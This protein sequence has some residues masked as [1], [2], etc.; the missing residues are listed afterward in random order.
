MVN[1]IYTAVVKIPLTVI[2]KIQNGYIFLIQAYS[3][4]NI[5]LTS[6]SWGKNK[7]TKKSPFTLHSKTKQSYQMIL[8]TTSKC[9][10]RREHRYSHVQ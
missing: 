4:E 6:G 2:M 5:P 3:E 7:C 8:P 10:V 1:F 9:Q